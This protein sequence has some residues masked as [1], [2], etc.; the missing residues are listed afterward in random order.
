MTWRIQLEGDKDDL[1]DLSKIFTSPEFSINE[2]DGNFYLFSNLFNSIEDSGLVEE[3]GKEFLDIINAGVKLTSNYLR[4]IKTAGVESLNSDGWVK[5]RFVHLEAEVRNHAKV[6]LQ[7]TKANGTVIE[8]NPFEPLVKWH[9]LAQENPLVAKAFYLISHDFNTWF[10]LYKL[11]EILEEDRFKPI[12]RK[13]EYR[14]EAERF[15]HTAQSYAALGLHARHIKSIFTA[16]SDPM[17]LDEAKSFIRMLL[18][19][20]LRTK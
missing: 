8:D 19:E 15:S 10:S 9:Q 18:N 13:G 20:W 3:K 17:S 7:I 6:G 12:M 2:I 11:L 1:I 14:K 5:K 4:E 16:P